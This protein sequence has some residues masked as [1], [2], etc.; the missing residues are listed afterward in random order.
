VLSGSPA[1]IVATVPIARPRGTH[2]AEEI[3]AIRSEI[4]PRLGQAK[5]RGGDAL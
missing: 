2:S 3:A 4:A 1:R 5:A